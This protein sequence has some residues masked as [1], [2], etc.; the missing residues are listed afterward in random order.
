MNVLS[1]DCPTTCWLAFH[2]MGC[3]V[4]IL[5]VGSSPTRLKDGRPTIADAIAVA[6]SVPFQPVCAVTVNGTAWL[7]IAVV[8]FVTD[9]IVSM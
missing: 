3:V 5:P 1:A 6:L 9:A 8:E 7:M 2:A 4:K